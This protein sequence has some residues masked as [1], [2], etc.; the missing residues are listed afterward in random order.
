MT[1]SSQ[2]LPL[3]FTVRELS[4]LASVDNGQIALHESFTARLNPFKQL[5]LFV[6]AS[7]RCREIVEEESSNATSF[8]A[9]LYEEVFVAPF[10]ETR[11]L[12]RTT[13]GG[14][15]RVKVKGVALVKVGRRE[16]ATTSKPPS[17]GYAR[18]CRVFHPK[19]RG[20]R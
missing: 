19:H 8:T 14:Y 4:V 13:S 1:H 16:I 7:F 15:R 20:G 6:I 18:I 5:L 10:L 17:F 12:I 2:L 9:M 11:V 3:L